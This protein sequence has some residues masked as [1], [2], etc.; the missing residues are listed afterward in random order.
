MFYDARILQTHR[1]LREPLFLEKGQG[2]FLHAQGGR[3]ILDFEAGCWAMSLG[4]N[5][6]SVTK[7]LQR[8]AE[9]IIHTNE[10]FMNSSAP[11]LTEELIHAAKLP[12]SKALYLSSGS[13]AVELSI[14][15]AEK[16]TER[17]KKLTFD[18][19][20]LSSGA[21]ARIPRDPAFWTDF[22]L[23]PCL[24]CRG[25]SCGEC[26]RT[27]SLE[28]DSYG[29]FVFEPGNA[30]GRVYLPPEKLIRH[31]C[32]SI[33]KAGGLIIANEVTTG[34]GRTGK[35][36]GYQHYGIL[37]DMITLGKGL[38]NGYPLSAV[39]VEKDSAVKIEEQEI[40]Y[41][42]SHIN[43]PLGCEVGLA[44]TRA[45]ASE[46]W[47]EKA[48]EKGA[49]FMGKLREIAEA[50]PHVKDL[51]GRGLMI[52]MEFRGSPKKGGLIFEKMLR[53]GFFIGFSENPDII[54]FYPSLIV[55]KEHIQALCLALE[56]M[57]CSAKPL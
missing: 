48:P 50:S 2:M 42:Q 47:I 31:L 43:D 24:E 15:L 10:V 8:Q 14:A 32:E 40:R 35:W 1:R 19:S 7:T 36:F 16:I 34:F 44:V 33:R 29:A 3:T 38:G 54:R 56:E 9:K 39:F 18:V 5:H 11:Q 49:Y 27:A 51:R 28:Y 20:F 41:V 52:V 45:L 37:P 57:L 25:G 17:E 26:P 46:K 23:K 55:E 21:R 6:E 4:H 13:E 53:K 30:K 12:D 22:P